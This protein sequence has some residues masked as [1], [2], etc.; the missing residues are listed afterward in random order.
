MFPPVEEQLGAIE[1]GVVDIFSREELIQ[2][3]EASRRES[4]PLRV[5]AGFDPTAPDIHLGHAVPLGKMRDFQ[6]L[7]H[8]VVVIV[9][10]YTARVGDPS[11]QNRTRP[12][13]DPEA[14]DTAARSYFA[15]VGKVLDT[16]RI[17]IVRN[18]DWFGKMTFEDVIRL[19]SRMTIAQLLERDDFS[20]RYK[21]GNP[22]ALHEFLY[23]M[24]QGYDSVRV[25]ADVE[26]GATEQTFNLLVG[27]A[28]QRDAGQEPQVAITLPMLVGTDGVQKM[29]KSL[30]NYIGVTEPP[31][32]MYG[33]TMSIPDEALRDYF[34]LATPLPPEEVDA[35]LAGGDPMAAKMRLAREIVTRYHGAEV[36]AAAEAHFSRTV[37]QRELPDDVAEVRLGRDLLRDGKVWLVKLVV[38]CGFAKTNGEARRLIAQGGV[39]LDGETVTETDLDIE[40]KDGAILRAGKR[41]F[42][43]IRL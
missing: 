19:A 3:L 20:N 36:A 43:R 8:Q 14:I 2:K 25:R 42:A 31:D 26:L 10:D 6:N 16:Q 39:S 18:G 24:M 17:E 38:H 12:D 7:G 40:P 27:R 22:I 11:G 9:G 4:R 30:G 33:K 35:I 23:P 1:R 21:A 34:V 29:S 41:N 13:L 28:F 32:Q 5:K 37:R 15:Q